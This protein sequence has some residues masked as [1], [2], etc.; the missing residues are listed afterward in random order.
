MA[1]LENFKQL[2]VLLGNTVDSTVLA[3]V[4]DIEPKAIKRHIM[5]TTTPSPPLIRAAV[6]KT[7]SIIERRIIKGWLTE[8]R[9]LK[10]E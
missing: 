4:A 5:A 3:T 7:L 9:K 6:K 8:G 2:G 10:S 1:N